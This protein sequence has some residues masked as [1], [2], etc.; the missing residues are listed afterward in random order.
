MAL[1]WTTSYL[2]FTVTLF[3]MHEPLASNGNACSRMRILISI[4]R[5]SAYLVKSLYCCA[6]ENSAHAVAFTVTG[7][8]F[9]TKSFVSHHILYLSFFSVVLFVCPLCF[10]FFFCFSLFHVANISLF[11]LPVH[12]SACHAAVLTSDD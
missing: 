8:I 5:N 6:P 3:K 2:P 10:S 4:K 11:I 12:H 9:M 7:N 1:A